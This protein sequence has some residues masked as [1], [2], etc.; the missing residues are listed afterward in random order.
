MALT[1]PIHGTPSLT[2]MRT[3]WTSTSMAWPMSASGPTSMSTGTSRPAEAGPE[4]TPLTRTPTVT[5]Q[6]TGP[7]STDSTFR[8]ATCGATTPSKWTTCAVTP[9][10]KRP[11]QP[12]SL[13]LPP[14]EPRTQR[15]RTR[16]VTGC[17]TVGNLNTGAGLAA[18]STVGTTGPWT[19]FVPTMPTGMPTVT[20]WPTS[21]STSGRS[22]ATWPSMEN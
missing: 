16:T 19:R 14:T 13:L 9:Q 6:P 11:T 3:G 15:T 21:V 18:P 20:A 12:T 8:S 22:C 5:V 1:R 10:A 17:R 7:K 4:P 2:P